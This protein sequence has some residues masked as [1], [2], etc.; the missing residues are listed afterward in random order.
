LEPSPATEVQLPYR[1]VTRG[2]EIAWGEWGSAPG[3]PLALVHG[4]TGSAH[5]FAL[6]IGELSKSR[7][8]I[9]LDHRGHGTST[10]A[11]NV[12]AYTMD[13]LVDDVINLLGVASDGPADLL[14]HS[15][16][17]RVALGVVLSRPD[18]VRS[19]ILMDTTAG[20]FA[21]GSPRRMEAI[22]AFFDSYDPATAS[23]VM[24]LRSPED[25]L[26]ESSTPLAWRA[27][28]TILS[29]GVDPYAVKAL[30][31]A[32]FDTDSVSV[33]SQLGIISCPTT[34]IVGSEDHPFIDLAPG[35]AQAIAGAELS[36]IE[37]AYHSPQLTHA[38]LWRQ[39]VERHLLR[40]S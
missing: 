26:I 6:Q 29:E 36:V 12:D 1:L 8:V 2:V 19:L 35:L 24:E 15:M 32:L 14:G 18:L 4:F 20:P 21:L 5:D 33:Q 40:T 31:M 23:P 10:K 38:D 13:L 39:A 17:G 34:V 3:P 25:S 9:A 16:G 7:R 22:A 30:G 11:R 28:K 27:R 37:G